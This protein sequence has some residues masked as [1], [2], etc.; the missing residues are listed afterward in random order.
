[1]SENGG[2]GAAR[3]ANIDGEFL[4]CRFEDNVSVDG[5]GLF[6]SFSSFALSFCTFLNNDGQFFGGA[7]FCVSDSTPLIRHCT[8][9]GNSAHLGGGI[10]V[11]ADS[12]PTID[13]CV[14]AFNHVGSGV[15]VHDEHSDVTVICSDI[16]GN[17]DGGFTGHI[18]DQI[19]VNG[20][21]DVNPAFCDLANGDLSLA[22]A[23]PCLPLN[24]GCSVLIGAHTQGCVLTPAPEDLPTAVLLAPN[25]P[26]P[27]NPATTIAFALDVD[28]EVVLTVH[29]LAGRRVSVLWQGHCEAGRHEVIWRGL[30]QRGRPQP[31]GTYLYRLQAG[32]QVQTRA[33]ALVR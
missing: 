21:I 2:G 24:N 7:I 25:R 20:N 6:M 17:E 26:N 32:D 22:S 31:S 23:S 4:N 3:L 30:D 33:M 16:H 28:R 9:V 13:A 27:F 29:D 19:G 15:D 12:H 14:I 5:A 10:M 11:A 1:M 8:L 18:E